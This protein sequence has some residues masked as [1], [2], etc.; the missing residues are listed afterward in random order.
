[1]LKVNKQHMNPHIIAQLIANEAMAVD[2]RMN[3]A[4][5]AEYSGLGSPNVAYLIK[6]KIRGSG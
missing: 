1:M 3:H 2:D 5:V 4:G 6:A